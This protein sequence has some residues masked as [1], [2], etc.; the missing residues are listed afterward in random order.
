L[1]AQQLRDRGGDLP[2]AL[3]GWLDWGCRRIIFR[4]VADQA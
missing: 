3:S 1:L 2:A 4:L